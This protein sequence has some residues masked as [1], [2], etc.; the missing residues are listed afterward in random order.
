MNLVYKAKY[1]VGSKVLIAGR[2]ALESFMTNWKYHNKL[3][4]DQLEFAET[5]AL[6]K[7]VGFYHGGDVLYTLEG[8]PG[9][10]H[11]VCL[12]AA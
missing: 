3:K 11:E 4:P 8:V 10:W 5:M 7:S 6:V 1:E 12:S 2:S 9:I